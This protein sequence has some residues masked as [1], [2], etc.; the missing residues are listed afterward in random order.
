MKKATKT[1]KR[2]APARS[3]RKVTTVRAHRPSSQALARR[4]ASTI[5]VL[6][7]EANSTYLTENPL[8]IDFGTHPMKFSDKETAILS[9]AVDVNEIRIKPSGQPY[10]PHTAYTRLF[11]RA[12]GM[13]KWHLRPLA[14]PTRT[15]TAFG[16]SIMVPYALIVRGIPVATAWGEQEYFPKNKDQSLGDAVES[17]HASAIRRCAKRL[18]IALEMWDKEY[19]EHFVDRYAVCVRVEQNRKENGE[20][21][22]KVVKLWRLKSSPPFPNELGP[23]TSGSWGSREDEEHPQRPPRASSPPPAEA[24]KT[25]ATEGHAQRPVSSHPKQDEPITPAQRTRL[26][27]IARRAQR[28]DEEVKGFLKRDYRLE[29][30]QAITRR[31]YEDICTALEHPGPLRRVID[32][33]REREP[34]DEG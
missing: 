24:P 1:K 26:W 14:K 23:A 11:N 5:D 13:G 30:S 4:D 12:L 34:G 15:A 3:S 17:T 28:T 21:K 31:D 16:E 32:I 20:W 29:S 18:G 8:D 10:L 27:T 2:Q 6:P 25:R 7:V 9:A 33:S 22:K 19:I